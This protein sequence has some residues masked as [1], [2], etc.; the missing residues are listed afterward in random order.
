MVSV[1]VSS[2]FYVGGC[3]TSSCLSAEKR[4]CV[5]D[6]LSPEHFHGKHDEIRKRRQPN[7]AQW[8]LQTPEYVG[9]R[10]CQNQGRLLWGHGIRR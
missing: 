2:G 5:L 1:R 8:I 4:K 7:T 6:W 9:W 3:L 10:M